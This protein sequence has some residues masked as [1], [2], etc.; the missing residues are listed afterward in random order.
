MNF[1][2]NGIEKLGS[3][4]SHKSVTVA[5]VHIG[6]KVTSSRRHLAKILSTTFGNS[7]VAMATDL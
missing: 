5:R 2:C 6:V 3:R 1:I 7:I 4:V